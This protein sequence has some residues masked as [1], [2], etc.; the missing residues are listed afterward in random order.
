MELVGDA[1]IRISGVIT[2]KVAS[3]FAKL[4]TD[5]VSLLSVS[6]E[7]G[8]TESAIQIAEIVQRRSMGIRVI[9]VC[10]SSCA[11]Y[12]FVAGFSRE[13]M[14]DAVVGWHGGHS[15]KPFR[16]TLDSGS[17]L[18]E[19][20]K[21]LLREQLLYARAKVSVDLIVYSGI[22]KLGEQVERDVR[23]EYSLWSPSAEELRR[24]GVTGLKMFEG[25]RTPEA[26]KKQLDSIGLSGQS[27]YTGKAYSY[28][29]SFL[30]R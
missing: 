15:F 20:E 17:R 10:L 21:I 11:N 8:V 25:E 6:S 22:V 12:L 18:V 5:K 9:D 28:L 13:V 1:E 29:P 27:I 24:L 7:G 3:D 30:S 19:K 23:R 4:L 2:P 14:P 16:S 26:I